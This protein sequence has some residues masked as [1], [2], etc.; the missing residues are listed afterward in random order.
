MSSVVGHTSL[1]RNGTFL[2]AFFWLG[3]AATLLT[4]LM[5]WPVLLQPNESLFGNEIVGRHADAY[6]VIQSFDDRDA[7]GGTTQ[8]GV[9]WTGYWLAKLSGSVMAYN[10]LVLITFPLTALAVFALATYLGLSRWPASWVALLYAFSPLH[11]AHSAYHPHVAQTQWVPL[12]LLAVVAACDRWTPWRAL[13]IALAVGLAV[14]SNFYAALL[15]AA[16][17]PFVLWILRRNPVGAG[18]GW[19]ATAW[20]LIGVAG[21]A[22]VY[23]GYFHGSVILDPWR[24][25]FPAGDAPRYAARWFSYLLPN[26]DHPLMGEAS[27]SLWE[28]LQPGD[29]L[30]EQQL[31][32]GW[33]IMVLAAM[34]L[35]AWR[36]TPA[37]RAWRAV[38]LLVTLAVVAVVLSISPVVSLGALNLPT[39]SWLL[40]AVAPMFRAYA[41]FAFVAQLALLLLAGLALTRRPLWLRRGWLVG[42]AVLLSILEFLPLPPWRTHPLYPNAGYWAL[43][44]GESE[45]SVLDCTLTPQIQGSVAT[46]VDGAVHAPDGDTLDCGEPDL[47]PKLAAQLVTHVID[48]EDG[49]TAGIGGLRLVD[50]RE[51]VVVYAVDAPP[52]AVYVR[53]WTGFS[54]RE[55]S[56]ADSLRWGGTQPAMWLNNPARIARV[57]PLTVELVA[58]PEP[59]SVDVVLNSELLTTLQVPVTRTWFDL[60]LPLEASRNRLQFQVHGRPVAPDQILG[61]GDRRLLALGVGGLRYPRSEKSAAPVS[62]PDSAE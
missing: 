22:A 27:R 13:A 17:L 6:S 11:I 25:A 50:R 62:P 47:A 7:L 1:L 23:V 42:L 48:H 16:C 19:Q 44:E 54:W 60:Q 18:A 32:L 51:D 49:R 28:R 45:W 34:G 31:Y 21:A 56:G 38:P 26:V 14:L 35:L 53:R 37:V 52:A 33:S 30:I 58:F 3:V 12:V 9:D 43:L 24:L 57:V 41:R 15:L 20:T 2:R 55:G 39:P 8:P 61:N 29:A 10:L 4:V 40:R 5:A 59:R 36:R 46:L